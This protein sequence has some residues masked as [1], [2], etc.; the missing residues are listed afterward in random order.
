MSYTALYRN[1][2]PQYLK[3]SRGRIILLLHYRT[4]LGKPYR[5][6]VFVLRNKRYREDDSGENICK[7]RKL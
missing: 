2:G 6:C 4:R 7:S 3:M 1:S 5:T